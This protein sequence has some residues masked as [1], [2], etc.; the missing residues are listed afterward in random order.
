MK[1]VRTFWNPDRPGVPAG[2]SELALDGATL[3]IGTG[4]MSKAGAKEPRGQTPQTFATE[5]E[6][7][8]AAHTWVLAQL[9]A[10]AREEGPGG[11]YMTS[12]EVA[13]SSAHFAVGPSL[14]RLLD[15]I[16]AGVGRPDPGPYAALLDGHLP[17]ELR[18]LLEVRAY[19]TFHS[20]TLGDCVLRDDDDGVP[21]PVGLVP[22]GSTEGGDLFVCE[23]AGA[24]NRDDVVPVLMLE[25][26]F[27][28]P[29]PFA[30]SLDAW[31]ARVE[32]DAATAGDDDFDPDHDGAVDD[33]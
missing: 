26:G 16:E 12:P 27:D 31:M 29:Y 25:N 24:A 6:A 4:G 10:G 14:R 17:T 3:T 15:Q 18:A 8:A 22:I 2:Y 9:R 5:G 21:V 13:R 7:A 30:A 32:Q 11:S 1:K 20:L 23:L 33:E 19:T 28:G